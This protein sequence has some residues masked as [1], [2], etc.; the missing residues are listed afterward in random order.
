MKKKIF[1][2]ILALTL[3]VIA[4]VSAEEINKF[5]SVADENVKFEDIVH[6]DSAIAGNLVD[7]IGNVDGIGFVAGNTVNL[8]GDLEYAFVAGNSVNIN[9]KVLKSAYVAGNL[10]SFS[11]DTTIERDLFVVGSNITL[12]G[13]LNRDVNAGASKV[14]IT[15]DAKIK[16]DVN[17]DANE[18]VVEKGA[19]INGT[20]KYN[21]NAKTDISK[22]AALTSVR[23]Y[24]VAETNNNNTTFTDTLISVANMLVV[25]AVIALVFPRVANKTMETVESKN[26]NYLKSF[27][28]GLLILICTPIIALFLLISSIGVS[29][30]LIVLALYA[31]CLYLAYIVSGIALGN[32]IINKL[33][34]QNTNIFLTGII[35]IIVL[36]V[37][38]LIPYIGGLISLIALCI[39]LAL[40]VSLVEI[41]EDNKKADKV[42]EA[43]IEEKKTTTSKKSK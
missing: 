14:I 19:T 3:L 41:K 12:S 30:S 15:S 38:I 6:G 1:G 34:K 40:I 17:I 32:L 43:K 7:M 24:D 35:G 33:L 23:T 26:T 36:K 20:L 4:P 28:I 18:I 13:N 11:K 5:H 25:F 8:N 9:G 27:G 22:E 31:V 42:V 39:G 10:I 16:G 2:L 21:E 29:L 37:I